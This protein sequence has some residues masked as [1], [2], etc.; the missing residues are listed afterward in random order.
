[1]RNGKLDAGEFGP[2]GY[3]LAHEVATADVVATYGDATGKPIAYYATIATWRGSGV[4][5]LKGVADRSFAFSDPGS[6]SGYLVPAYGLRSHGIDPQ[7]GVHPLFAGSHTASFEAI[8]NHK[9][10]VGELNS[11]EI[12]SAMDAGE[13]TAVD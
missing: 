11:I 10:D 7:T 6:T 8:R 3:V 4:T 9:A 1:M 2:L 12:Q 5:S 13:Y